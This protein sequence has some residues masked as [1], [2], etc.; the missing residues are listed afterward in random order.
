M[1]DNKTVFFAKNI[2]EALYQIKNVPG[3]EII[4]GASSS[5]MLPEKSLTVS[6]IPEL[7]TIVRHERYIDFGPAVTLN[8]ILELDKNRVPESLYEATLT[9]ANFFIRNTATIGGNICAKTRGIKGTLYA[10]LL[11]LGAT[12]RFRNTEN[13]IATT[14]PFSKFDGVPQG[15]L[16]VNIRVPLEDWDVSVFRRCGPSHFINE[17]SASYCFLAKT[18]KSLLTNIKIAMTGILVFEDRELEN[19][20][21][22]IKLPLAAKSIEDFLQ[23]AGDAF[24][25]NAGSIKYNSIIKRQFLNLTQFSLNQLT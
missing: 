7:K 1:Q 16:L 21:L 23:A 18:E 8:E 22:G 15:H 25:K 19:K 10:P 13:Q 9:T 20:L 6:A 5:H 12:L 3:L 4:G 14:I 17:D 24:D 11:A 2:S